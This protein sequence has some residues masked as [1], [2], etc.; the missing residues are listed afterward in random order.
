[1]KYINYLVFIFIFLF[2]TSQVYASGEIIELVF[3]EETKDE[4]WII[5]K[6]IDFNESDFLLTVSL[7][8]GNEK[9][10]EIPKGVSENILSLLSNNNYLFFQEE[11]GEIIKIK[12]SEGEY[13]PAEPEDISIGVIIL[14]ILA[15]IGGAWWRFYERAN[16]KS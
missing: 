8:N 11:N 14:L 7:S 1:M 16:K 5:G 3:P 12:I 2:S 15:V 6:I 13:N 10:Y 4:E 9:I